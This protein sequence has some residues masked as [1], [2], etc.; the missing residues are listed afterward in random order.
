MQKNFSVSAKDGLGEPEDVEMD[1]NG[2]LVNLSDWSPAIAV[3]LAA[4]DGLELTAEHWNVLLFLRDYYDDY[5][6]APHAMV[7]AMA[8]G[9]SPS[10]SKRS[11]EYLLRLFPGWAL[12]EGGF[13]W[14]PA[15]IVGLPPPTC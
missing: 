15:R 2:F 11:A 5:M 4:R 3:A 9:V 14:Q 8:M 6:I 7:I 13:L 12:V 10:C 1:E